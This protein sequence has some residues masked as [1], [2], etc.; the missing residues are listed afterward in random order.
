MQTHQVGKD[1]I[2]PSAPKP[3]SPLACSAAVS[4]LA[5]LVSLPNRPLPGQPLLLLTVT[6]GVLLSLF[7][8]QFPHGSPHRLPFQQSCVGQTS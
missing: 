1:E 5:A 8:M 3:T 4:S 7:E 2:F 6:L